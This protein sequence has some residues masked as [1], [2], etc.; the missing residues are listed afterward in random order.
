MNRRLLTALLTTV[1]L[2]PAAGRSV[3]AEAP[4]LLEQSNWERGKD[5]LPEPVLRRVQ[6][7]EYRFHVTPADAARFRENY[8]RPFWAA[9]AANA[10]KYDLDPSS[11]ALLEKATGKTPEFFFGY[12]FPAIE[13]KDP[14]A[15]CKIAWN[16][17]A[18]SYMAGGTG[19]SFNLTGLERSGP[20]QTIRT[21]MEA[22]AYTG[23]HDGPIPNP[24]QVAAKAL[25][26]AVWPT[27]VNG[28]G[29]LTVRYLDPTRA[30]DMWAYVPSTRRARRVNASMRSEP[31]GGMD[32]FGDDVNCYAGRVEGYR[33]KLVGESQVLAPIVGQPYALAQKAVSATRW[34]IDTPILKAAFEGGGSGAP[35]LIT[36]NLVFVP[37]PVWVVE[38][39]SPDPYYNFGK[40]VMYFDKDMYRIYWK[41]VSNRAGEYFYNAMCGYT[42]G[43][44]A[45]R[46]LSSVLPSVVVGVND[47]TN[48]AAVAGR[49]QDQFVEHAFDPKTF[50]LR[51]IT[52]GVE[53]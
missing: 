17:T 29:N 35:W 31:V 47:K 8:S 23:R 5:L 28:M 45:D 27:A 25:S 3:A 52:H 10:G 26:I 7:G 30:D 14:L 42:F 46:A 11:C 33:W 51:A 37:R 20:Y 53:E 1:L 22:A 43:Q 13:P 6:A 15:G 41:L 38:G 32:I 34:K 48:R 44:T 19:A 16:F 4:W 12:P 2:G 18:A 50:T 36:E 39:E 49:P 21:K 40:V 9:S 24:E